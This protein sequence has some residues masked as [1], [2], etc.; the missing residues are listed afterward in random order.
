MKLCG[1]T[2][3]MPE[4]DI[5]EAIS[6]CASIG[7][8]GI[9][10]RCAENGQ[11]HLEALTS[12][13]VRR[14]RDHAQAES[15]EF[16]CLTP[17][18]RDF[19]DEAA[20]K[21]SLEGYRIACDIARQLDCPTV[22][23]ISGQWP[24]DDFERDEVFERTVEGTREAGAIAADCGVVLGVE[25]HRGQLAWSAAEA[26]EFVEAIDHEAV[27]VLYDA[28]WVHVRGEEPVD[29]A[30]EMLA[31]WI[32]HVHAKDCA[33]ED[34]GGTHTTLIGE[35][36]MDWCEIIERLNGIGYD[37]WISDEYEKFWHPERLPDPEVGMKHN[38]DALRRCI[39]AGS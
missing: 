15:V 2:M 1:H 18:Y 10:V 23:A 28:Y 33:R 5:F 16:A 32:V 9:E 25:T 3:G 17:Y 39:A 36:E 24:Q 21:A 37:G 19:M 26:V 30:V 31:P 35:G 13:D 34:D 7:L 29:K 11:M 4:M 12:D 27:G 38:A 22:R 14:I 6:F 8:D 20:E